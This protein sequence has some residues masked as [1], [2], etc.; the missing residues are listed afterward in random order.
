MLAI[1]RLDPHQRAQAVRVVI[2]PATRVQR[3][4]QRV[5]TRMPERRVTDIVRQRE[6][7]G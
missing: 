3:R 6:R 7:F 5:L 4:I 2:E 1:G